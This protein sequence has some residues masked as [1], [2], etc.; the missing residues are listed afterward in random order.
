MPG[1]QTFRCSFWYLW[2]RLSLLS[3][4][5]VLVG[6]SISQLGAGGFFSRDYFTFIVLIGSCKLII[7]ALAVLAHVYYFPVVIDDEGISA[8]TARGKRYRLLWSEVGAVKRVRHIGVPC[9]SI[10]SRQSDIN[11]LVPICL[12]RWNEFEAII[13]RYKL[14]SAPS[15]DEQKEAEVEPRALRRP[16][17]VPVREGG[18]IVI[19]TEQRGLKSR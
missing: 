13:G 18:F 16:R 3:I 7:T 6:T 4:G 17:P 14:P 11:L 10:R 9:L 1:K 5:L 15:R 8:H 19:S 2:S 12:R